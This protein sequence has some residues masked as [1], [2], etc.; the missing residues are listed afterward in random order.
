[1]N[2][3]PHFTLAELTVSAIAARNGLRNEPQANDV[4]QLRRLC[5][6]ILEPLRAALGAPIIVLSGYRS[7]KVN[8]L[9]G[10]SRTSHH[11][12]GRAADIIVPGRTPL[13]VCALVA[14]LG[15]PFEQCIHEFGEW[16]HV[17]VALS[18]TAPKRATLTATHAGSRVAYRPGLIAVAA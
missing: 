9:A 11:M 10:G 2:L 5:A 14:Q 7:L 17:S 6:L 13:E 18:A 15:L 8:A 1:M 4:D 16:C 12:E 3:S